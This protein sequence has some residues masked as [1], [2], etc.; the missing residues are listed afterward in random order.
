[1]L[2]EYVLP[3]KTRRRQGVIFNGVCPQSTPCPV[4]SFIESFKRVI[5]GSKGVLQHNGIHGGRCMPVC[6]I[7]S[8]RTVCR[9]LL[10]QQC[11]GTRFLPDVLPHQPFESYE[12]TWHGLRWDGCT[13][14]MATSIARY[15][16]GVPIV[17]PAARPVMFN[18]GGVTEYGEGPSEIQPAA[19]FVNSSA[20]ISPL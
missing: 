16:G 20:W 15:G 4:A 5:S 17:E 12:G 10:G 1:M 2:G 11:D 18:A 19:F 6:S 3:L 7:N 14:S 13:R 9:I 8:K